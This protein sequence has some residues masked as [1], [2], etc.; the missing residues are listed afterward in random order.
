M[1]R[2]PLSLAGFLLL[3]LPAA[4]RAQSPT[5]A[6][7]IAL[8]REGKL[9][10]AADAWR[11]VTERNPKDARAWASLG[12]VL[13]KQQQYAQAALAYKKALSLNPKLPGIALNLGL[14]EFKQGK[15]DAAIPPLRAALSAD[16]SS[17]QARSLLGMSEYGA[18]KFKEASK[19]LELAVNGDPENSELHNVLAQSC[20]F[21][22]SYDCALG[23]FQWI[24]K[25]NPDSASVHMLTGE[26]LDGLGRTTE[27]IQE[28]TVA[29]K[30]DARAPNVNFGL[31]YLYWKLREYD[32]AGRAFEAE[33][34]LDH[35]NPQAMAYLGDVEMKRGNTDKALEL[36]QNA[37]RIR[38]DLRIAYVDLG[39][40]L[41]DQKQYGEALAALQRGE[42]LDP[43]QPEV[44]YRL[45]RLY[46]AMGNAEAAKNE[47]EKV[48]HLHQKAEEDI[49]DKMSGRKPVV[50]LPEIPKEP[51]Q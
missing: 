16:S 30:V 47:F 36:F 21:A 3:S 13:S 39:V 7:A 31:G 9:A 10:E 2:L 28:F 46:Q 38:N 17:F 43:E 4:A 6:D 24:L 19:D 41:T 33:L 1:S 51:P 15:F 8:E 34:A 45:G 5:P 11:R 20:L 25:R 48:Q 49:A 23:E 37:V 35:S 22:K 32:D 50:T 42:K 29:A 18:G 40:I 12:V 14:A 44:H 26:A 27:A